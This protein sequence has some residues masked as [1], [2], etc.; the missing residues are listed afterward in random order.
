MD[1]STVRA[2]AQRHGD[3]TV[4]GD[5][6]TAGADLTKEGAADAPGVMKALPRSLDEAEIIDV[7]QD[8]ELWIV[9]IAYRGEGREVVV[10]SKWEERGD[11]PRIVGL[12][13]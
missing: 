12:S 13:I 2:Q 9:R 6:A 4:A 1:E 8:G 5:L 11:A 3:A 7:A 10:E